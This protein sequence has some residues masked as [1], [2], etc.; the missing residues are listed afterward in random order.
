MDHIEAAAPVL[1]K[2]LHG[3]VDAYWRGSE[4]SDD[5]DAPAAVKDALAAIAMAEG[6]A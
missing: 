4:D 6:G 5:D 2:A 1:L 3:M